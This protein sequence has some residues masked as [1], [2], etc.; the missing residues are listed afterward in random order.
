MLLNIRLRWFWLGRLLGFILQ[1][2]RK[3]TIFKHTNIENSDL[4]LSKFA[5]FFEPRIFFRKLYKILLAICDR[6]YFINN[7]NKICSVEIG[8]CCFWFF[9]WL[10]K[11]WTDVVCKIERV[12]RVNNFGLDWKYFV[13][14]INSKAV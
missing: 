13:F 12:S 11:L 7:L 3:N 8:C 2:D 10:V 1:N 5:S 6:S 4:F 9:S 14:I